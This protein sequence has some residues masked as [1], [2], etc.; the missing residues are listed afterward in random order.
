MTTLVTSAAY[1]ASKTLAP[2]GPT[3]KRSQ[4]SEVIA[5]LLGYQT[6]AALGIEESNARL[7]HHLDD[8]EILVLDKPAAEKRAAAIGIT[9]VPA[10][11]QACIDAIRGSVVPVISVFVGVD[12][13]YDSYARNRMVQVAMLSDEVSGTMADS[14][15]IFDDDPEFQDETPTTDNLWQ[16]R[17]V[18]AIEADGNWVGSYDPD[19]D[20]MF[21]GDT[22]NCSAKL[23]Y[24]KA[25]RSGLIESSSE[26]YAHR[27]DSWEDED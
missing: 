25:G 21:N 15:A 26:A 5:A 8:A 13:F 1:A 11:L 19:A 4:L 14:N 20:R 2:L 27:D 12:D 16:A 10:V 24:D 17:T 9:N 6:Y 7:P 18:W 22:L 3:F 23:S